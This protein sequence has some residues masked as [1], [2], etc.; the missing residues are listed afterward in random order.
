M[1]TSSRARTR[2]Y[3]LCF[4]CTA[5]SRLVLAAADSSSMC[6]ASMLNIRTSFATW[7]TRLL[8]VQ[9]IR[10]VPS[11]LCAGNG[12]RANARIRQE[13]RPRHGCARC[14]TTPC[15]A[16]PATYERQFVF[17]I[18]VQFWAFSKGVS[19]R[20][21]SDTSG[22]IVRLQHGPIS[23]RLQERGGRRES[24]QAMRV[25]SM[26]RKHANS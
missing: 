13:Q 5:M 18:L 1:S 3:L 4:C 22:A 21:P 9:N 26:S 25:Q 14:V 11:T 20:Q 15:A 6:Q 10:N 23:V 8:R 19:P 12:K 17:P 16:A 7:L 24:A 2:T